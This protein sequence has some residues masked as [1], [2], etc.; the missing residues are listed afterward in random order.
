MYEEAWSY[1]VVRIALQEKP[2]VM[3]NAQ[4]NL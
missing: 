4:K 3:P 2:E 1:M